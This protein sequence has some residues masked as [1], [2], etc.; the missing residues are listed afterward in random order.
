MFPVDFICGLLVLFSLLYFFSFLILLHT[1][2]L[3]DDINALNGCLLK[4]IAPPLLHVHFCFPGS[5]PVSDTLL[6]LR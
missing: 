5:L 4:E 1:L 6:A 2:H 3:G